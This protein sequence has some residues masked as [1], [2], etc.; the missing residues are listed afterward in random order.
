MW[1]LC[2]VDAIPAAAQHGANR[3]HISFPNCCAVMP[4]SSL[5]PQPPAGTNA[6]TAASTLGADSPVF[7]PSVTTHCSLAFPAP[8]ARAPTGCST[9]APVARSPVLCLPHGSAARP[10]DPRLE[11]PGR[12]HPSA[13]NRER[14]VWSSRRSVA[15]RELPR[16]APHS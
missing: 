7:M 10:Q 1:Q 11:S 12:C 4:A 15:G 13:S 5:L 2:I 6:N 14:K 8:T 9:R 3:A 16:P